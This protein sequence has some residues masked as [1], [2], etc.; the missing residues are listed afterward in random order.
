MNEQKILLVGAKGFW[1]RVGYVEMFGLPVL[2]QFSDKLSV[3]R[4]LRPNVWGIVAADQEIGGEFLDQYPNLKV[5]ARTGTGYDGIDIAAAKQRGIT[6]TRVAKL[7]AEAVAQTTIG[8][9]FA[10]CKNIPALN[11]GMLEGK[12]MNEHESLHTGELTV[13]VVGLGQIGQALT[14]KLHML[15]FHKIYGWTRRPEK[16]EILDL[17]E[18]TELETIELDALLQQSDIVVLALAL[19]N[20]TRQLISREKLALMKRSAYLINVCRG[21]VVDEMALAEAVGAEQIAGVA[22]D[23]YS[24]EPNPFEQNYMQSLRAT[25]KKVMRDKKGPRIILTPHCAGKTNVSVERISKQVVK[26]LLGVWKGD[27]TD[28]EVV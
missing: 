16:P 6:V 14:R 1:S 3:E 23:V 11:A 15:G 26:C 19:T 9:I 8:F 20:D 21:A 28:V 4:E 5:I 22:L 17:V 7:N 24:H 25:A 13:G 27:L 18:T 2:P 10:L 12:W